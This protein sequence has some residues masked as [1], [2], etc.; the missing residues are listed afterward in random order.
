MFGFDDL[1]KRKNQLLRIARLDATDEQV[2]GC[3]LDCHEKGTLGNRSVGSF[4]FVFGSS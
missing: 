2:D 1:E 3:R 4:F